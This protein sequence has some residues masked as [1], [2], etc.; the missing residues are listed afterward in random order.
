MALAADARGLVYRELGEVKAAAQDFR[1]SLELLNT[2]VV[3]FPTVPRYRKALAKA[4]NSLG[5]LEQDMGDLAA[6]EIHLR[7]ELPLVERLTQD[8]PTIPEHARELA[9]TLYNLGIVLMAE[10]RVAEA[11]PILHRAIEVTEPIATKNP[12]DVQIR[13]DLSKCH[14]NLGEL[15]IQKGDAKQA[16]TSLLRARAINES[17]VKT[18]PAMPRYASLLAANLTS[19]GFAL[20]LTRQPMVEETYQAVLSI[21]E[22][23]VAAHPENIE[24][25][26]GQARCLRNLGPLVAA[27]GKAELAETM[28]HQAL[29]LLDTKD[30][31]TAADQLPERLRSQAEVLNNLGHLHR[32]GAEEAFRR[33]ITVSKN[34]IA[35]KPAANKD[36]H[37]L[38]IAQFNLGQ[39]LVDLERVPEA[40]P[41]FVQS[42]AN[43]ESLV[44]A[45]PKSIDFQSHF[46]LVLEAQASHLAKCDKPAEAK[47]ALVNAVAHQRQA[48]LLSKNRTDVRSLLGTHLLELA[49]INVNLGAYKEAAANALEIP[50]T[51]P[52]LKRDQGC[53][54]AARVLARLVTHASTDSK[55]A[56]SE[57]DE[58]TRN[59]LGRTIVLLRE[60]IDT[61]PNLTDQIK[62]DVDIKTLQSRPEFQSL[63]NTLVNLGR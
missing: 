46:G 10:N 55:L 57:R 30:K 61:N 5:V 43:F 27:A 3:E 38:A 53:L 51:V 20:D 1:R 32:A 8:F 33:S 19:L 50:N 39:L 4:C 16:I 23:L 12:D 26:I 60:A 48:L 35:Q 45:A 29:T 62:A 13:F 34:L 36:R 59:Y 7:Q 24:Y 49:Q 31:G 18:S 47:T 17:L 6:A 11:D 40:G 41:L 2:L 9:R 15:L 14:H 28:Y 58:L 56:Q 37:T 22:R 25:R 63:M 54:D 44:A 52:I 42:L 21:Y